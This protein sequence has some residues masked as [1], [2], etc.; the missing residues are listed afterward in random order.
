MNLIDAFL[1]FTIVSYFVCAVLWI[2][3]IEPIKDQ[4][5]IG[6]IGSLIA[7]IFLLGNLLLNISAV[8]FVYGIFWSFASVASYVG[9]VKWNLAYKTEVSDAHQ[10]YM[11]GW[12]ALIAIACFILSI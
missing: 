9:I 10:T 11:A 12:D 3:K 5:N 7:G 4:G 8:W 2:F 6:Y 1:W